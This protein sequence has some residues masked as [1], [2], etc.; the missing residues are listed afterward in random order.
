MKRVENS[1]KLRRVID[2]TGSKLFGLK[3]VGYEGVRAVW[4]TKLDFKKQG[5]LDSMRASR[6][7]PK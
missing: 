1:L 3:N 2:F 5:A 7:P 4:Y 6:S